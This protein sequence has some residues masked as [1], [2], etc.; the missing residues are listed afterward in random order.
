M[1]MEARATHVRCII[2]AGG[3]GARLRSRVADLP[4]PMAPVADRPFLELLLDQLERQN[5]HDIVLSLGYKSEHIVRYF[6]ERPRATQRLNFVIE[7]APMGTGGAIRMAAEQHPAPYYLV[8][9]GDSFCDTDLQDFISSV[10]RSEFTNGMLAALQPD[11]SRYGKL[12]VH[13]HSGKVIMIE[14][15]KP[16]AGPGLINAGV[17]FLSAEFLHKHCPQQGAFSFEQTAFPALV[18]GGLYAYTKA[19]PF[20]DIGIPEDYDFLCAHTEQFFPQREATLS[21]LSD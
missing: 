4:K 16:N 2:L 7:D 10:Y 13:K 20:I 1:N 3:K 5:I 21:A 17:Y 14:E 11:C 15:K 18:G 9:N 12:T 6:E 19:G 8:L